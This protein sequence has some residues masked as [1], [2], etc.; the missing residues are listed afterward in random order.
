MAG[1]T[2]LIRAPLWDVVGERRHLLYNI[3]N[4]ES[5]S[6]LLPTGASDRW[7]FA[8]VDEEQRPPRGPR[9]SSARPPASRTCRC[10]SSS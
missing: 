9:R 4:A 5:P 10:G 6:V 3:T 8:A 7:L 1:A 2:T